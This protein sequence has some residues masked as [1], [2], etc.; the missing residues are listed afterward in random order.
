[1]LIRLYYMSSHLLVYHLQLLH[2][3]LFQFIFYGDGEYSCIVIITKRTTTQFLKNY[4]D[5][6]TI[7]ILYQIKIYL[8]LSTLLNC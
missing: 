6:M 8:A 3:E 1:M 2:K 5:H 4:D 7:T